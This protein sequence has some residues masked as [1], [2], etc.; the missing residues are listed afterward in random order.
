[1]TTSQHVQDDLVRFESIDPQARLTS[2]N[3]RL[4]LAHS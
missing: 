3:V 2:A 1:M 4:N